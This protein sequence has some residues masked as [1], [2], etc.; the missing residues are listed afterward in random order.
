MSDHTPLRKP[1]PRID[2]GIH[3]RIRAERTRLAMTQEA[4]AEALDVDVKTAGRWERGEASPSAAQL[5]G[6]EAIGMDVF[7][8]LGVEPAGEAATRHTFAVRLRDEITRLGVTLESAGRAI[9]ESSGQG[10]RDVASG[11]KRL[12]VETLAKL[13]GLGV[14]AHYVLTGVRTVL[15]SASTNPIAPVLAEIRQ[16]AAGLVAAIDALAELTGDTNPQ[17]GAPE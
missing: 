17:Q 9:G 15:S 3:D 4:L 16:H 1:R 14:D 2:A 11:R 8:I 10:L 7:H 13:M 6:M 12:T 5:A